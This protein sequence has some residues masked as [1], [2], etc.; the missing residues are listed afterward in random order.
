M[1]YKVG[2]IIY[3]K[4]PITINEGRPVTEMIVTNMGDRSIQVCSHYHFFESNLAL[5]F[6]REQAFGKRLDIPS[7]TAVRFEPGEEKKISLVPYAGGQRLVG[8]MGVTMGVV[9]DP[10]VKAKALKKMKE[11]EGG[12]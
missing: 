2:E 4:E 8:F 10:D 5:K 1:N 6:N 12:K 11:L 7:G 3:K 9:T